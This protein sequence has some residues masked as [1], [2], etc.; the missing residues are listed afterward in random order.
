MIVK[1]I[2]MI[3]TITKKTTTDFCNES[4]FNFIFNF[5]NL[6]YNFQQNNGAP[7]RI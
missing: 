6:L 2:K 1:I 5:Y 4:L 3:K 7:A